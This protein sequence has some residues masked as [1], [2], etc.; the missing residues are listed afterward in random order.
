MCATPTFMDAHMPAERRSGGGQWRDRANG[1]WLRPERINVNSVAAC[2][3][4][5]VAMSTECPQLQ[6]HVDATPENTPPCSLRQYGQHIAV[7]SRARWFI[8]GLI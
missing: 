5:H 6:A 3:P 4:G 8:M 2:A 7:S 1:P